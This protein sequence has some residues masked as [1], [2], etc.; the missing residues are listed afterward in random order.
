MKS[1]I[2]ITAIALMLGAGGAFALS[3][4]HQHEHQAPAQTQP[5]SQ[6]ET[7]DH[8]KDQSQ[9][10]DNAVPDQCRAAIQSM[11]RGC[12]E[13]MQRM[14]GMMGGGMMGGGAGGGGMMGGGN[15]GGMTGG[16]A[17][18]S[19]ADAGASTS[20]R[21]YLA[22][23]E[24]MHGPM[25]EGVKASDPDVAFVRGMIAHHEGAIDMARVVLAYGNDPLARTWAEQ[26]I[27]EQQH[28]ID[29]MQ[30]WLTKQQK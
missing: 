1:R 28:Q 11:P 29:E 25:T 10:R 8:P 26:T 9:V 15:R 18:P 7:K 3:S 27:R 13:M 12:M 23:V 6:D 16:G 2:T 19:A 22:A 4:E 5:Q 17:S 14:G 21:A 20:T 30:A 24:K